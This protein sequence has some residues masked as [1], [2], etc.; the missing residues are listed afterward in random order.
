[1]K[2]INL[3]SYYSAKLKFKIYFTKRDLINKG[4]LLRN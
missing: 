2:E 3:P 1:M 4:M